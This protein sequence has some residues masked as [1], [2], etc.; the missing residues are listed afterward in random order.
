M[1]EL[2]IKITVATL[3]ILSLLLMAKEILK[4]EFKLNIVSIFWIIIVV[5]TTVIPYETKYNLIATLINYFLNVFSVKMIYKIS[6][7]KATI[8]TTTIMLIIGIVDIIISSIMMLILDF[9]TMRSMDIM[10]ITNLLVM[11]S[12]YIFFKI[13]KI[14]E[15]L[16]VFLDFLDC[17]KHISR[18]IF[19]IL[20]FLI[21]VTFF[22]QALP[23]VEKG[24]LNTGYLMN[25]LIVFVFVVLNMIYIKEET[26]YANLNQ[27]YD[28]LFNC[29]KNFEG[30]IEE[31]QMNL[32]ESKNSLASLLEITKEDIT[33]T[34]IKEML[35]DKIEIENKWIEQLKYIPK[36][37]LKGILYYKLSIAKKENIKVV[38]D[39]SKDVTKLIEKLSDSELKELS[40]LVG[41]YF[42]NAIEASSLVEDGKI[43]LEVYKVKESLVFTFSNNFKGEID[44]DKINQKGVSTKGVKRGNGLYFASKIVGRNKNFISNQQ[45]INDYYIQKL[46]I[47]LSSK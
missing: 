7:N 19:I 14:K 34:K 6:L 12:A 42:D 9:E 29:V 17:K 28:V 40:R 20:V 31:E 16:K 32:H 13:R 36:G 4:K 24:I 30:W 44:F 8:T 33:K 18:I 27:E 26:N 5:I 23:N 15:K 25:I 43:S 1:W 38:T 3:L 35:K 21:V 45:V 11:I 46:T 2:I 41:I 39:V 10:I 37:G 22:S 47:D